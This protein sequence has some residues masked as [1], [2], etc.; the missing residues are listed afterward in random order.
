MSKHVFSRD[1]YFCRTI[2]LGGGAATLLA[3]KALRYIN[4]ERMVVEETSDGLS[5][6]LASTMSPLVTTP[7][8]LKRGAKPGGI[9]PPGNGAPQALPPTYFSPSPPEAFFLD[10]ATIPAPT[11]C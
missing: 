7:I 9:S 2:S 3:P 1:C 11:L 8:Q 4:H 6:G 5:A 10:R